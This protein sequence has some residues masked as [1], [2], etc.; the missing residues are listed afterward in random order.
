MKKKALKAKEP[1][2][3]EVV[4]KMFGE[5]NVSPLDGDYG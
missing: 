3:F 5:A 1:T 4:Q 2:D